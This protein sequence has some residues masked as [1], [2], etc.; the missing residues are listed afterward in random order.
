MHGS[1]ILM[2]LRAIVEAGFQLPVKAGEEIRKICEELG[3][4]VMALNPTYIFSKFEG[5][6][7]PKKRD[8]G[9]ER[10]RS[11]FKLFQKWSNNDDSITNSF[12]IIADDL[13][14]LADE[15]AKQDPPIFI[16]YEMWSWGT[17]RVARDNFDLWIQSTYAVVSADPTIRSAN[18]DQ[19]LNSM[20]ELGQTISLEI[21]Y[22]QISDGARGDHA[23]LQKYATEKGLSP[24][25]MWSSKHRPLPILRGSGKDIHL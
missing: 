2:K 23:K 25:Y 16:A 1:H 13:R 20:T 17:H 22:L 15:A 24:L 12:E 6:N 9:Y 19:F 10:S 18:V 14:Q 5:Q 3:I 11:L 21:F 7:H 8:A 4:V